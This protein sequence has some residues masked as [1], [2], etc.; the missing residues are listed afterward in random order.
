VSYRPFIPGEDKQ[1]TSINVLCYI[2]KVH[3]ITARSVSREFRDILKMA[4]PELT[5][6][7]MK[8]PR[9]AQ[10]KGVQ[11][12]RQTTIPDDILIARPV[13][14]MTGGGEEEG[15]TSWEA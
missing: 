14:I 2:C 11:K 5:D 3:S 9:S 10:N 6:A 8:L 7:I 12:K 4:K 15:D 1:S 13:L